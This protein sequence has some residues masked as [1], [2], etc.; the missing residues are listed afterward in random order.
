[1][2]FNT[3]QHMRYTSLLLLLLAACAS[4]EHKNEELFRAK[5][6]TAMNIFSSNIEGPAFDKAGNLYIVNYLS[7]GWHSGKTITQ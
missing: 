1:M 5:D 3:I 6:L 7:T 2:N 4:S